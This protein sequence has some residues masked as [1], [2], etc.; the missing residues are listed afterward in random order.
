M[1][2]DRNGKGSHMPRILILLGLII[3]MLVSCKPKMEEKGTIFLISQFLVAKTIEVKS[4]KYET[5]EVADCSY[6]TMEVSTKLPFED[7]CINP[8]S[9]KEC[10]DGDYI[11]TEQTGVIRNN[12]VLFRIVKVIHNHP[13]DV[14][15][16]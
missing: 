11:V 9:L 4:C 6:D 12:C 8:A 16:G 15:N 5:F 1:S 10:H 7:H 14:P 3:T 13:V 2:N